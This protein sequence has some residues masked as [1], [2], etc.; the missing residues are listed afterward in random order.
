MKIGVASGDWI[1]PQNTGTGEEN[2]GGSGWVRV[3]QYFDHLP[4]EFV[5]GTLVW[6]ETHFLIRTADDEL[7]FAPIIFMHR[8]MHNNLVS[9]IHKARA[10]G[11]IIINDID[12]WYWGLSPQ[13]NAFLA[14]DPKHNKSEDRQSYRGILAASDLVIVSTPYLASRLTWIKCP[15]VVVSN[16][17]DI[18]RFSRN[19]HMN[20]KPTL[21][22]V[23]STAHR[24]GDLETV[25]GV[26]RQ[27][28]REREVNLH[29]SGHHSSHPSFASKIGVSEQEVSTLPLAG[30]DEYP[31]LLEP[32]D[33]GIVPLNHI[34]FNQAKSDIKGMEYAAAGIPFVAQRIDSYEQLNKSLGIGRLAKNPKEWI[35]HI[36]KLKDHSLRQEEADRNREALKARDITVG[37]SIMS[38]ILDSFR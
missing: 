38:Q 11:Q 36:R 4:Y 33:I 17:V 7:V 37:A 20:L 3:A 31:S 30:H 22:W 26:L 24:S 8:L 16:T 29:H 35:S 28:S 14:T 9:N 21:G 6:Y 1:H 12:D 19:V 2:W 5:V 13:N 27:L 10:N 25:A 15:M 18:Q 32:I 34:P 23:G